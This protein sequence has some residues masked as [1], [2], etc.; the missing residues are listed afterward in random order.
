MLMRVFAMV[1]VASI[2]LGSPATAQSIGGKWL[3][4]WDADVR[5]DHDTAI[6]RARKPA[7]FE[8]TQRGDSVIGT[9]RPGPDA[10]VPVRGIFDGHS[11]KLSSGV[12]ERNGMIDGKPTLMKVRWDIVGS[13]EG[14][15]LGG[16]LL[17]YLGDR[18]PVPRHWEAQRAP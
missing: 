5:I 17:M 10:D 13:L 4:T 18:P 9:W 1:A 7:S 11:L 12:L 14:A 6:V 15:K 2:S 16:V 8:L 3:A